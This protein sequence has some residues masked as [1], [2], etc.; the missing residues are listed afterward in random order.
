M[1]VY[2]RVKKW[3]LDAVFTY[4]EDSED[5]VSLTL[6]V[7]APQFGDAVTNEAD[8]VCP[9]SRRSEQDTGEVDLL[10]AFLSH[11]PNTVFFDCDFGE[12]GNVTGPYPSPEGLSAPGPMTFQMGSYSRTMQ[13]EG[14]GQGFFNPPVIS[15]V[16]LEWWEYR[17]A[18]GENPLYDKNTGQ[19]L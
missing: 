9:K 7:Q 6:D 5:V 11:S 18:S 3:K 12:F 19:R 15:L 2:W 13:A 17:D 10:S 14:A 1:E 8:L 16:A 4:G